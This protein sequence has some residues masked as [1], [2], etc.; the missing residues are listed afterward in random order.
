MPR[1]PGTTASRMLQDAPPWAA[2][3]Y[4]IEAVYCALGAEFDRFEAA[5][6]ILALAPFPLLDA[7]YIALWEYTLGLPIAPANLTL[8]Q[9]QR[10]VLAAMGAVGERRVGARWVS[11]LS[12]ILGTTW[13]Y[14]CH[15]PDDGD[16][17][18]P[19]HVRVT[20]PYTPALTAP[21][22]IAIDASGGSGASATRYFKITALN[23]YGETEGSEEVSVSCHA[24]STVSM[25]WTAVSGATS[26]NVY[27]SV[28][29]G[30]ERLVTNV[31]TSDYSGLANA[32]TSAISPPT[33]NTTAS[34]TG[35]RAEA[36][37]RVITPAHVEIDIA[38]DAGFLVGVSQLGVDTL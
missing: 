7:T 9:R 28:T 21:T 22:D 6:D 35:Q 10:G 31:E 27:R 11:S 16:S 26:Y 13:S 2:K 30:A 29:S 23:S 8:S 37:L 20:L 5:K 15:D 34:P 25:E 38:Y 17:P 4:E 33:V 36:L 14:Q 12:S 32:S 24:D 19:H 3:I 18:D 1:T